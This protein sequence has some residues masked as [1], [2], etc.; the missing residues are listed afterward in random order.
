M[1]LREEFE[2]GQADGTVQCAIGT[3]TFCPR[4]PRRDCHPSPGLPGLPFRVP[5]AIEHPW[6]IG[7]FLAQLDTH[8]PVS[9][10]RGPSP[11]IFMRRDSRC[12]CQKEAGSWQES[13]QAV[14]APR[15]LL[16]RRNAPRWVCVPSRLSAVTGAGNP[17][18]S[19]PEARQRIRREDKRAAPGERLVDVQAPGGERP[20]MLSLTPPSD[21]RKLTARI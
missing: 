14:T 21:A 7:S 6:D 4:Y 10:Q 13:Q 2:T 20:T 8:V 12:V 16:V 5:D 1:L 17:V 15:R 3:A 18:R 19:A 11:T 9:G